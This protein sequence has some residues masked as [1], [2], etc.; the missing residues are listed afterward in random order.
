MATP[1]AKLPLDKI[2]SPS[3]RTRG[4]GVKYR[5]RSKVNGKS[6]FAAI[7]LEDGAKVS[8][9][10]ERWRRLPRVAADPGGG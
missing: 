7:A 1:Y 2:G 3:R 8:T 6:I 5:D 9:Q 10:L 4:R